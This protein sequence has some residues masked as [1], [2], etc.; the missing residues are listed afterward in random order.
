MIKKHKSAV[1]VILLLI[2]SIFFVST[3]KKN[4]YMVKF[5]SFLHSV[6]IKRLTK[7]YIRAS[8]I[9]EE[10]KNNIS[11]IIDV[12][13]KLSAIYDYVILKFLPELRLLIK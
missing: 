1:M 3:V 10:L 9:E 4:E 5:I 13:K 6:K 12:D 8:L 2:G 11:A 7:A